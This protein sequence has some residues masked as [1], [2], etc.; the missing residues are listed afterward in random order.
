VADRIIAVA[1]G[2]GYLDLANMLRNGE[3]KVNGG[4]ISVHVPDPEVLVKMAF[5][6]DAE[7]ALNNAAMAAMGR[8][9]RLRIVPGA[10]VA[11]KAPVSRPS[12]SGSLK[13]Q[14]AEEPVIRRMQEKFGAEIR[15]V[16]DLRE[17][18]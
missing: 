1:E 12:P 15:S 2:A 6:K 4:E 13:S 11:V 5:K 3:W 16:I 14:V 18:G 17:K 8:P 7:Q 10:N 9:A